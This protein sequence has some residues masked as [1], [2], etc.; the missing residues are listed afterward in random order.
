M[1]MAVGDALGTTYEFQ[2][3]AQ[4]AYPVLATGPATDVVGRGPFALAPA[5]KLF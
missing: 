1:G 5:P 2:E 3:L 4:P